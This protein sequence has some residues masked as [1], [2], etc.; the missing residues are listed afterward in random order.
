MT[1]ETPIFKSKDYK[2][3]EI[4]LFILENLDNLYKKKFW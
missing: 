3:H 4:Y 1:R 2:L